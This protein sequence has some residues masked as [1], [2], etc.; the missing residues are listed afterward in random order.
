M[1]FLQNLLEFYG[2]VANP[3]S[4][5]KL[6]ILAGVHHAIPNSFSF[7]K[8]GIRHPYLL[9]RKP[10]KHFPYA[11]KVPMFAVVLNMDYGLFFHNAV[12]YLDLK[13]S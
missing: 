7:G 2:T 13:I 11:T 4:H 3:F 5:F 1:N 12:V 8:R 6:S 9:W 10:S